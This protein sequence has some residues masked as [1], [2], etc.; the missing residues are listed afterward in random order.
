MAAAPAAPRAG[1]PAAVH[2]RHRLMH[3]AATWPGFM[4]FCNLTS[5]NGFSA[6]IPLVAHD[7]GGRAGPLLFLYAATVLST[8]LAWRRWPDRAGPARVATVSLALTA[9]AGLLLAWAPTYGAL[10]AGTFVLGLGAA[11]LMPTMLTV[12]VARAPD[13]E[14]SRAMSSASLWLD[15][16]QGLGAPLLGLVAVA[17]GTEQAAF[18]AAAVLAL[19]GLV[20]GRTRLEPEPEPGARPAAAGAGA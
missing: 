17:A 20:V 4:L 14:R 3:P 8:R 10:F 19:A 12:T 13:G 9:T 6:F 15:M 18:A 16:S 7:R 5:S 1:R 11:F 2:W